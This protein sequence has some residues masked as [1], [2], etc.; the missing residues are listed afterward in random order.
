MADNL[1]SKTGA[2]RKRVA[3]KQE[4]EMGYMRDKFNVS[5][6]QVAGAIRA[7]GNNR[8]KVEAYLNSK[9]AK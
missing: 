5:S 3:G 1:K 6:Q 7:V 8:K 2:D 9:T 4:W